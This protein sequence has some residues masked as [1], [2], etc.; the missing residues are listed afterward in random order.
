MALYFY[1]NETTGDLVYSDKATYDVDGYISLGEQVN[2]NPTYSR[3][4]FTEYRASIK[5]VTKDTSVIKG[6]IDLESMGSMFTD[7]SVLTTLDLSGF[8]TS[9]VVDMQQIFF[10][11]SSLANLDL[12]NL[13][14]SGVYDMR[15]AFSQCT[16]LTSLYLPTLPTLH[17]VSMSAAFEGCTALK[18]LDLSCLFTEHYVSYMFQGCSSLVSLDLSNLDTL[19][20]IEKSN[21]FNN[22]N[23]LRL[24]TISDKMS[25]ILSS[26]PTDQYYPAFGGDPVAKENLTA[27]TWVRDKEDLEM[28]TSIVQQAQMSQ[29]ISRRIGKLNRD[30]RAEIAAAIAGGGGSSDYPGAATD[31]DFKAYFGFTD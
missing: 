23:N 7:C 10:R 3:W 17:A 1:F 21:V 16:L 8:N 27:G 5:S 22:C 29:A 15:S 14:L 6:S 30:L 11:C 28:V 25:N 4:I 2:K 13:D 20:A 24:I 12:S 19:D 18:N 26:L 31:E 9:N